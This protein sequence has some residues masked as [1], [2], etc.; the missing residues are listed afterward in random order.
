MPSPSDLVAPDLAAPE[1]VAPDLAAAFAANR[2]RG[3]VAV[4]AAPARPP[5]ANAEAGAL[6][7]RFPRACAGLPEAV[8]VNTAGGMAGGDHFEV[9]VA[10][11]PGARLAVTTAAAEKVYRSLGSDARLDVTASLGDGAELL[12]L[13]Q[14]T[15]VFDRARLQRTLTMTLAGDARLVIAEAAVFGRTAMGETV[16]GGAFTDRWRIRRG[17]RLV[18][19]ENFG[20]DGAVGRHL[21]EAAIAGGGTALA[22]V[23]LTPAEP[24]AADAVRDAR[25]AFA[26]EVGVSA[27][28]GMVVARL[29]AGDGACLRHDLVLV[30]AALGYRTLPRIF[31]N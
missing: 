28:N 21:A 11:E 22:T 18:F 8:L 3:R 7:V 29:V 13:P 16:H 14:E 27:W 25:A 12:W 10:L 4:T 2:A 1:L 20:L 15:I 31:L 23:L 5:C 6:R 24:A 30:L 26:G 9:D 17:G 19:A